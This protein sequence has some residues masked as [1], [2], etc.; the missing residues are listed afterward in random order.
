MK[1][2]RGLFFNNVSSLLAGVFP[3]LRKIL[4]ED[5]WTQLVRDFYRVHRCR[6]PFFLEVPQEFLEYLA[7]EREARETDPPYLYEL[8]HYEWVELALSV[9]EASPADL[10][11]DPDGDLLAGVPALSPLAWPLAYRFPVHRLSPEYQ[12][13]V[14]PPEAS[15]YIVYRDLEDAVGFIEINAVTM[16]LVQRMQE[17]PELSGQ[18]Q[19]EELAE[20]ISEVEYSAL[21]RG[22]LE[23]LQ[24]LRRHD[25]LLGTRID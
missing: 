18:R 13:Q 24:T 23:T 15:F 25:V 9:E 12:P 10:A 4:G 6:T 8:A 16:R 20:E 2:Y 5:L 19:L 21:V 17:H 7:E 22:G 11:V 1:I 14:A 3:V